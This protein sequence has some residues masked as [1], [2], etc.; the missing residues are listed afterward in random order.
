MS[1]LDYEQNGANTHLSDKLAQQSQSDVSSGAQNNKDIVNVLKLQL[2]EAQDH[3]NMI[4]DEMIKLKSQWEMLAR[5]REDKLQSE[6]QQRLVEATER[7]ELEDKVE[8]G[9]RE[10]KRYQD[11]LAQSQEQLQSAQ[12]MVEESHDRSVATHEKYVSVKRML[13]K[14]EILYRLVTT[15]LQQ[16]DESYK[17]YIKSLLSHNVVHTLPSLHRIL[18]KQP[19]IK[20]LF[21]FIRERFRLQSF[22]PTNDQTREVL[23]LYAFS[24]NGIAQTKTMCRSLLR[25]LKL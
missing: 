7:L 11:T 8:A 25:L 3:N 9:W 17:N 1:W 19:V 24:D 2:E 14:Y 15:Q 4:Q 6:L 22:S 10:I 16:R 21:R 13:R 12:V 5:E 20:R 18:K 23:L